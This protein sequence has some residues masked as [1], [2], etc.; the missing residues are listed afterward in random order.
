MLPTNRLRPTRTWGFVAGSWGGLVFVAALGVALTIA[1]CGS[2]A[3]SG[4]TGG[5]GGGNN[6]G[7]AAAGGMT[8][9]TGGASGTAGGSGSGGAGGA[10]GGSG[11]KCVLGTS[12]VGSCV[13][14]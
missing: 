11:N 12:Q 3:K 10:A 7:D 9:S 6:N 13:L 14:Q 1:G 8:G 5:A 2:V 4:G